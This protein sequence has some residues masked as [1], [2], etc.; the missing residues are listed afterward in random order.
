MCLLANS[1]QVVTNSKQFFLRL[2]ELFDERRQKDHGSIHLTQ[3][4]KTNP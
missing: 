4:S 2:S 1:F 3:K